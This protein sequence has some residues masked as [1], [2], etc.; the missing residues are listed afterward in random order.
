L[1]LALF[2]MAFF[3]LPQQH[4]GSLRTFLLFYFQASVKRVQGLFL[5]L[6]LFL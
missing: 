5:W 1:F 6:E 4:L 2:S 3:V